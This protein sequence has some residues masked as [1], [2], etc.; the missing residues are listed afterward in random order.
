MP[1]DGSSVES[2]PLNKSKRP[3]R[4]PSAGC[5]LSLRREFDALTGGLGAAEAV[6]GVALESTSL[7]LILLRFDAV[8]V[9]T[10]D[11]RRGER[12]SEGTALSTKTMDLSSKSS[13]SRI[14][15]G[16]GG[17]GFVGSGIRSGLLC[18]AGRGGTGGTNTLAK[19]DEGC[20]DASVFFRKSR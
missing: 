12:G 9:C 11:S 4:L 7:T 15:D 2:S 14:V 19:G 5:P 16:E 3:C 18:S 6:V 20:R 10:V 17:K 1:D 13:L 8:M